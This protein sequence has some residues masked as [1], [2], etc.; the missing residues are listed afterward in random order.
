MIFITIPVYNVEAYLKRCIDS[1]LAQTYVDFEVLL[2]DDGSTDHSPEICDEY[3]YKDPRIKV[4]HQAYSGVAAA[5]NIGLEWYYKNSKAEWFFFVDSDDCIHPRCLEVLLNAAESTGTAIAIG[6]Y[7]EFSDEEVKPEETIAE[8]QKFNSED[9]FIERCSNI[10]VVWCK[11]YQ[12]KCFEGIRFPAGKIHED[13][14]T[15]Y[16]VI[17]RENNVSFIDTPLY[18]YYHNKTSITKQWSSDRV[19]IIDAFAEQLDFF[20]K[21]GFERAHKKACYHMLLHFCYI[22]ELWGKELGESEKIFRK[23]LRKWLRKYKKNAEISFKKDLWIYWNAYP[24]LKECLNLRQK[25][26]KNISCFLKRIVRR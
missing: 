25:I 6:N 19:V 10:A 4:V 13:E 18:F 3:S 24:G 20:K 2:I 22:L 9:F 21:N 15:T 7:I 8:V 11:L 23:T 17:F 16:K 12:R 14:F 26:C 5:R 1:I